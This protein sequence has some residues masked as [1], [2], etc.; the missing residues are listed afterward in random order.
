MTWPHSQ[1]YN[2]AI[3]SPA[4]SFDDPELRGGE[5][6]AN[7]MGL[8]LPRSGNFA[9]VYEFIGASGARW[10]I[11]CFTRRRPRLQERYREISRHLAQARLPFTV[12]FEYLKRGICIQGRWVPVLKMQ[13][14]DGFHL[15]EFVRNNVDKPTLLQ[16]L[17]R[18]WVRMALCLRE[19]RLAHADLQH[20]NV[21]LVPGNKTRSLAVKLIDYDGMWV[22]SLAH[23]KSLEVGH[24]AYQHPQRMQKAIYNAEVD[25]LPLLAITCALRGLE[26]GGKSL[27]DRHDTGDNLLF[28]PSDLCNPATS[29]LIKELQ[30]LA[31]PAI[32]DLTRQLL[33]GLQGPLD[34]VP[35]VQDLL[36]PEGELRKFATEEEVPVGP[37]A[38]LE[39]SSES[40]EQDP[41]M[42]AARCPFCTAVFRVPRKAAG[43]SLHCKR[44][45]SYFTVVPPQG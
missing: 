12:D 38:A 40:I 34:R 36:S 35:L 39:K 37:A 41:T 20:G 6:V 10:A 1:D 19:A 31:D 11:K 2:E 43:A 8:P 14:V 24:P 26:V 33:I 15:N 17:G 23:R 9:D 44:C 42:F 13:W 32:P 27:W 28:R 18:I 30:T 45:H 25:R 16:S 22:P 4:S 29:P 21:L 7:A 3:Q 5:P